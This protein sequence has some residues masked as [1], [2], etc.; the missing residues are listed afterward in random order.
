MMMQAFIS[1]SHN[2]ISSLN[3]LHKH[4]AQLQ[5][6]NL[7]SAWTD[8]EINAGNKLDS[9]ISNALLNSKIFIALTSLD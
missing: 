2:D 1:Y 6:E 4:L 7:I 5:R 9:A 3:I 8:N